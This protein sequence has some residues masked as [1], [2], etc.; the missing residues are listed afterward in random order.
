M[1]AN[2]IFLACIVAGALALAG[3]S[4]GNRTEALQSQLDSVRQADSL[5]QEDINQMADFINVMSSGLDSI[6]ASEGQLKT[7][8]SPEQNHIDK[9]RLRQQLDDLGNLVKRQRQRISDLE[10]I[11]E[12]NN[13]AYAQRIRS[14]IA[15]YKK[16]LDQKD[17]QIAELQKEL[18]SKNADIKQLTQNVSELTGTNE[19]LNKTVSAQQQTI[20]TQDASLNEAYYVIGTTKELKA[21][22]IITGGGL[23]SKKK[24]D[25]SKLTGAGFSKIDIRQ[26]NDVTLNSEKPKIMTQHPAGSYELKQNG[27]GSTTLRIT[28]AQKFWSVSKYLVVRL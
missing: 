5:H 15:N 14:L 10:K 21:K 13:S 24:V 26:W 16:Q 4:K 9:A 8:G 20:A 25:F 18:E 27:D 28:D 22:G 2:R 6:N 19:T 7:L 3:C 23:F 12:N 1:K 11:V 17:Q